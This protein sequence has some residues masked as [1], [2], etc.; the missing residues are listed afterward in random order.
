MKGSFVS[1]FVIT[2]SNNSS[3]ELWI[4]VRNDSINGDRV[5]HELE[6]HNRYDGQGLIASFISSRKNYP[7][8]MMTEIQ[9]LDNSATTQM[10][11]EHIAFRTPVRSSWRH[12]IV[13]M[14]SRSSHTKSSFSIIFFQATVKVVLLPF[15]IHCGF[16]N[17][18]RAFISLSSSPM[19]RCVCVGF[20]K[21]VSI[22]SHAAAD[23]SRH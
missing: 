1:I 12:N 3:H 4:S 13:C 2:E 22:R 8:R 10:F 5:L 11:G 21:L 15:S 17:D 14:I 23:Y 18:H 19:L 20:V 16:T 7:P 9:E 6:D